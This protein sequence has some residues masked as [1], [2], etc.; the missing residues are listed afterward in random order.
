[1]PQWR[2]AEGC[3]ELR[4]SDYGFLGAREGFPGK[5]KEGSRVRVVLMG[6]KRKINFSFKKCVCKSEGRV[7]KDVCIHHFIEQLNKIV[8]RDPYLYF[9]DKLKSWENKQLIFS[10]RKGNTY[11]LNLS[12]LIPNQCLPLLHWSANTEFPTHPV[13][14]IVPN[15]D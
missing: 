5:Q 10:H 9:I 11:D 1:M 6:K 8:C 2:P 7:N 15:E 4:G 13:G 12:L 3:G 14:C